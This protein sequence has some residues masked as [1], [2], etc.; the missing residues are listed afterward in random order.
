LFTLP[1][2]KKDIITAGITDQPVA[3]ET[4]IS[5]TEEGTVVENATAIT[6]ANCIKRRRK[7]FNYHLRQDNNDIEPM[8]ITLIE[9]EPVEAA[10]EEENDH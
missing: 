2:S 4:K 9:K 8:T 5:T 3:E 10:D 1:L 6:K 7:Y